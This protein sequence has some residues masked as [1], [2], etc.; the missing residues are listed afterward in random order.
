M[1]MPTGCSIWLMPTGRTFEELSGIISRLSDQYT[2]PRFPP[3]VTLVEGL[4]GE[5]QDLSSR[6]MR[7]ASHIRPFQITLTTLD[8]LDEYFR[9]LF[10]HV[11]E[12]PALLET[13]QAA[14]KL[15]HQGRDSRFM[16]H[17]SLMYGDLDPATKRQIVHSLST[18]VKPTFLVESL[19]LYSISGGPEDWRLVQ[20]AAMQE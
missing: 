18:N 2:T 20:E 1:T 11:E 15:F 16:P 9:C 14:R 5:E 17:L 12:S 10:F 13:A 7:L 3:H 8:Y 19:H 4:T 6:T